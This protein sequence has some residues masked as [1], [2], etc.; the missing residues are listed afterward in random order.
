MRFGYPAAFWLL[1]LLPA[2]ILLYHLGK[3]QHAAFLR[4]F[5]E[6]A[7]LQR[8]PGRFSWL[9]QKWVALSLL[10]L[11]CLSI[12][13]ALTDPRLPYGPPQVRAGALDVVMLLDISKS[14]AAE[15]YGRR[16]RLQQAREIA[17]G[18][19]PTLQGNRIGL[20]T[21]AGT[22]FRQAE[23]TDDITALDFI[24]TY[25]VDV[26]TLSI[27]GSDIAGALRT[28]LSLFPDRS[29]RERVILLL[30]DGGDHT[31]AL[32]AVLNQAVRQGIK[33]VTLGLGHLE[34]S[35]IPLYDAH[36]KFQDYM[37]VS[38]RILTTQL[39]EAPLQQIATTTGGMYRRIV[40]GDEW[41]GLF[42]EPEVAGK[43]LVWEDIKLFQPLLGFGL[44]TFGLHHLR[45]RL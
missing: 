8:T 45:S 5:G 9:H 20:V 44:L 37:R 27:G 18:L 13:L 35:R 38:Q 14:M 23:L 10:L 19:L 12:S 26:S 40:R 43:V 21:F 15:D 39:N 28:G 1:L 24:L 25:W 36:H 42:T 34:P 41:H 16:S 3:R 22:S 11:P 2:L 31:D 29:D 33:I 4:R 17:R 32:P 30:S 6:R 7:L